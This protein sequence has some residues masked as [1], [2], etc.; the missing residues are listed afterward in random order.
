M[1]ITTTQKH[2][3]H[4]IATFIENKIIDSRSSDSSTPLDHI[5][6]QGLYTDF[7]WK[8]FIVNRILN[9]PIKDRLLMPAKLLGMHFTIISFTTLFRIQTN[10]HIYHHF[11]KIFKTAKHTLDFASI[12]EDYKGKWC[13]LVSPSRDIVSTH[14]F[15]DFEEDTVAVFNMDE[16]QFISDSSNRH[17]NFT[18]PI[19]M[20]LVVHQGHILSQLC[21]LVKLNATIEL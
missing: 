20:H 12:H 2:I 14:N 8:T 10:F 6:M 11:F 4:E 7:E 18:L 15:E 19:L 16:M 1:M 21:Q 13:E 3:I 9:V 17:E 5:W